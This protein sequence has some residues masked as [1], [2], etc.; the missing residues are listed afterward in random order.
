M[1]RFFAI[2]IVLVGCSRAEAT[3][4]TSVT[5]SEFCA[6]RAERVCTVATAFS[7]GAIC[8][9]PTTEDCQLQETDACEADLVDRES[10]GASYDETA[11][12]SCL[13]T[14]T[15]GSEVDRS[16]CSSVARGTVV[17]GGTCLGPR[18]C[19]PSAEGTVDCAIDEDA[20]SGLCVLS[21]LDPDPPITIGTRP[22][23][24][25]CNA[26]EDCASTYCFVSQCTL[27]NPA[28]T[29]LCGG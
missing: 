16:I 28:D 21:T 20:M 15:D 9:V 18:D 24:A 3:P 10:E 27:R 13:D 7:Q 5:R 14:L 12:G 23:G 8:A 6:R 4:P 25:A 29:L 26:D 17:L 22:E 11:G 1:N 19:S 2:A